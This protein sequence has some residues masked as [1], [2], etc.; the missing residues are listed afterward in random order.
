M[1]DEELVKV[2]LCPD[3]MDI[4]TAVPGKCQSSCSKC[5]L[6]WI[7]QESDIQ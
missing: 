7:K 1:P 5:K 2:L 3:A 4:E 6:K